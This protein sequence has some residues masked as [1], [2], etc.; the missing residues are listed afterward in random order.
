MSFYTDVKKRNLIGKS[1]H[2]LEAGALAIRKEDKRLQVQTKIGWKSPW[3]HIR[4]GYWSNCNLW[5]TLV[6]EHIIKVGLPR[7]QWF[8]PSVCQ[9]CFKVVARPQTLKQLFAIES[10][11]VKMDHYSKCGLDIRG[12]VYGNYGAYWYN[13]SLN[14]GVECYKKVR[15]AVDANDDLGPS[16]SVI[17]KRAC[18]EYE[19]ALGASDK[20]TMTPE[21][22]EFEALIRDRMVTDYTVLQQTE[23]EIDHVHE[24]WIANAWMWGDETVLEYTDGE[25]LFPPYVTYHHLADEKPKETKGA[26]DD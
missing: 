1:V 16:V 4:Q 18:T 25:P 19:R 13:R 24:M 10:I 5:V 20:Y 23:I 12:D 8:V 14:D 11:Q 2:M 26:D 15:A 9:S 21:N 17:L 3:R 22:M 7:D 6:F